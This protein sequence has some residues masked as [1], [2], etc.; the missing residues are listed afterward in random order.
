[1]TKQIY[2]NIRLIFKP[3]LTKRSKRIILDFTF[4][5]SFRQ[6]QDFNEA[7]VIR[8]ITFFAQTIIC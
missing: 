6:K 3:K 7:R 8:K 2:S 4:Q 1:M 5:I